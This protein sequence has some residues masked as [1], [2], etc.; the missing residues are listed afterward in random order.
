M[1]WQDRK[2]WKWQKRWQWTGWSC[3]RH[4]GLFPRV[5]ILVQQHGLKDQFKWGCFSCTKNLNNGITDQVSDCS[6]EQSGALADHENNTKV[7]CAMRSSC[8]GQTVQ[9]VRIFPLYSAPARPQQECCFQFVITAL[10]KM[11]WTK[12]RVQRRVMRMI[13]GLENTICEGRLQV[14]RLFSLEKIRQKRQITVL[15][16]VRGYYKG[17]LWVPCSCQARK[18]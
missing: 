16:Y 8:S 12:G 2:L 10:Q 6:A 7:S 17:I 15:K 18:K 14:I 4:R 9:P 5:R 3:Q 11:T 13:R 1:V